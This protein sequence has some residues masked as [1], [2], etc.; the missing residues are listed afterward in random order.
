MAQVMRDENQCA[1]IRMVL[2]Q[3]FFH[4]VPKGL[5]ANRQGFVQQQDVEFA[6]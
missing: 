1:A 2:P 3:P 4:L 5:I 6:I